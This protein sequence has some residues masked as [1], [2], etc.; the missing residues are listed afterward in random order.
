MRDQHGDFVDYA[1]ARWTDLVR[2]AVFMGCSLHEA[3]DLAQTTLLRCY[4]SWPKVV[5]AGDRDAYVFKILV[6]CLR[7]SHRRLASRELPVAEL[8]DRAV[9]DPTEQVDVADSVRR[10][11]AG[12]S[13]ANRDAVVLRHLVGL[14]EQQ[15]A[16]ALGVAVGTVKSR[17]ARALAQLVVDNQLSDFAERSNP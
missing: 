15:T 16:L 8:P 3:Q 9:G 5:R 7:D 11:L 1:A 4:V 12:L 14:S 17:T 6:N 13:P 2:S 10:A